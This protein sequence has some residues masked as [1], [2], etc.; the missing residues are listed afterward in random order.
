MQKNKFETTSQVNSIEVGVSKA[1]DSQIAFGQQIFPGNM[2]A[3]L[4]F[5]SDY[6][7]KYITTC[8]AP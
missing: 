4:I 6:C 2:A 8:L 3:S 1:K 5:L 7:M